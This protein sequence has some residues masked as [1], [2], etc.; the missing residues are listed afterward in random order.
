M[1]SILNFSPPST[2]TRAIILAAG[3]GVRFRPVTDTIPKPLVQ[4]RGKALIDWQLELLAL[5]GIT[6]VVINCCYLA[7]KL[8]AHVEARNYPLRI[9]FSREETALETGGGIKNAL[10]LLGDA[11]FFAINSDVILF[12]QHAQLLRQLERAFSLRTSTRLALLLH[13]TAGTIG[14]QGAGDFYCDEHGRLARRGELPTAPYFFTGVQLI[15]PSVFADI[16]HTIFSM[17]LVYN[18]LLA[19]APQTIAGIVNPSGHM[20]HVGD[21]EGHAACEAFL[22]KNVIAS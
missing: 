8:I 11:P 15:H 18:H 19:T 10:H 17:N 9:T 14:L 6:H 1:T 2:V 20:L 13:P 5:S 22:Q 16:E 4:V 12:P 21:P 7:E 3:R